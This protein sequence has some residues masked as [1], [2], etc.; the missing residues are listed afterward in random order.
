M[1]NLGLLREIEAEVEAEA[2][3]GTITKV[4]RDREGGEMSRLD[5]FSEETY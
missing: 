3:V 5:A 4:R 2:E 1:M